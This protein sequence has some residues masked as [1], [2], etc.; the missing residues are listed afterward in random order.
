M[1]RFSRPGFETIEFLHHGEGGVHEIAAE[2]LGVV[3]AHGAAEGFGDGMAVEHEDNHGDAFALGD[4]V[5]ESP[6]GF[7]VG[8]PG[9]EGVAVAVLEDEK[10]IGFVAGFVTGGRVDAHFAEAVDGRRVV[11]VLVEGAVGDVFEIE[12]FVAGEVEDARA[13]GTAGFELRVAG[14]DHANAVDIEVVAVDAGV[15]VVEGDGPDAPVV[16]GHGNLFASG[17]FAGEGDFFGVAGL[18]AEGDFAVVVDGGGD[19]GS[20]AGFA[21]L[22]LGFGILTAEDAESTEDCRKEDG[23]GEGSHDKGFRESEA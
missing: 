10:G 22:F 16:A 23:N 11:V 21:L 5:V 17:E 8:G 18:D 13:E 6:V 9:G 7:A 1:A 15:D 3:G 20:G 19:D 4:E 12:R 2:F 14:I